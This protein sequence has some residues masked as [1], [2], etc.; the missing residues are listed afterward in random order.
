LTVTKLSGRVDTSSGN[1]EITDASG[2][3]TLK[4]RDYDIDMENVGGRIQVENRNGNVELRFA[5]PPKDDIDVTNA[6]AGITLTLPARAPFEIR[7]DSHSGEIETEFTDPSLKK[8]GGGG[9]D[10]DSR[11]EG[12]VG[13]RGPK[14]NLKTSYGSIALH[15]TT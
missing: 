10:S 11:L 1:L 5:N 8:T 2:S 12:K 15:K 7:A 6:S 9:H 14:I 4:T 13:G 3:V